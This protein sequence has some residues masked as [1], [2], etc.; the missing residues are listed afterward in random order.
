MMPESSGKQ[1]GMM[2]KENVNLLDK[3]QQ[4]STQNNKNTFQ[5][6]GKSVRKKKN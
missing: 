2:S 3:S 4:I 6:K 1:E 5:L